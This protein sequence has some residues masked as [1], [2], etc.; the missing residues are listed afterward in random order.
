MKKVLL[1]G[2]WASL[3]LVFACSDDETPFPTPTVNFMTDPAVPEVGVPI[4]F[5]NLTINAARYEWDFGGS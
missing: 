1:F 5:E 4:M 2:I 3:L